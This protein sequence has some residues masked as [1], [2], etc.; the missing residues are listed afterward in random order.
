MNVKVP[1]P[2]CRLVL[3]APRGLLG[4]KVRCAKCGSPFVLKDPEADSKRGS[5]FGGVVLR[6]IAAPGGCVTVSRA[7]LGTILGLSNTPSDA[8]ICRVDPGT[9]H[10]RE[11]S[12][13]ATEFFTEPE[14]DEP[15]KEFLTLVHPD[16]RALARDGFARACELGERHDVVLRLRGVAGWRF[17]R[18]DAQARYSRDGS[19]SHVRCHFVDVTDR[20]REEEELRR[21]TELLTAAN[22]E[23][24]RTN[25]RLKEAHTQLVH[26]ETLASLG[27][28]A[29]GM[30]HEINNPLAV[31]TNNAAVPRTGRRDRPR[32]ARRLPGGESRNRLGPPRTRRAD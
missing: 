8:L 10:I 22:E 32:R 23:L 14:A 18:L 27:T 31:A 16:D 12:P 15:P 30:A 11:M 1:C 5:R 6:R 21:R 3:T 2:K 24:R 7:M 25:L 19:L 9:L 4:R 13:A 26:S 20:I 29:A 28:L 17:V